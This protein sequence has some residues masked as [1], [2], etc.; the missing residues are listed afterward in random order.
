MPV[1]VSF[2]LNQKGWMDAVPKDYLE[3]RNI[4]FYV[5]WDSEIFKT[6]YCYTAARDR[7]SARFWPVLVA[8]SYIDYYNYAFSPRPNP[9]QENPRFNGREGPD[10]IAFR[11][12]QAA[13]IAGTPLALIVAVGWAVAIVSCWRRR[14]YALVGVLLV[15]ALAVLGALHFSTKYPFE[16][17]GVTK[18]SYILY[19]T[20]PLFGVFGWI[21]DEGYRRGAWARVGSALVGLLVVPALAYA[22]YCRF[23]GIR[24][25]LNLALLRRPTRAAA[26]AGSRERCP[27]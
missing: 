1:V 8:S 24:Y 6:P 10:P 5:G 13:V 2:E 25:V 15:P 7:L 27:P 14:R 9:G 26:R 17:L 19:G 3:R 23:I 4:K 20:L 11:L 22:I 12:S 18:G 16:Q 21:V